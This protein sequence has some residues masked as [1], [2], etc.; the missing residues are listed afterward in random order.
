MHNRW[1]GW[2]VLGCIVATPLAAH[3]GSSADAL[4]QCLIR[5]TTPADQKVVLRWAFAT[6]A[7]DPDVA[8]MANVSAAQREALNQQAGALVTSLLADFCSQPVQQTL[9][10]EGMPGVQSAFE[11]WGRWA[12]TGVIGEPHVAQGMGQ[13][14][15]YLDLGKLMNLLPLNGLPGASGG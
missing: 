12:I 5:S 13:L 3:A 7:L 9:L 4:T 11:G 15:N 8:S 2:V 14:L 1:L 6:I 10:N